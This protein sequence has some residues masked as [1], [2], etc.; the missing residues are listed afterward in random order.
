[1]DSYNI[2]THKRALSTTIHNLHSEIDSACRNAYDSRC[3]DA[4]R[5][6]YLD[7]M[8]FLDAE[9]N[10]KTR[11]LANSTGRNKTF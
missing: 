3:S 6:A 1:M 11:K 7:R 4:M 2:K 9:L 8:Y 10:K 5:S